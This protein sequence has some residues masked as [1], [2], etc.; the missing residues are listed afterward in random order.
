L[1]ARY[2]DPGTG[3]FLSQ[4]TQIYNTSDP[5]Q[6][7][8]YGYTANNP[9]NYIDPLGSQA[10]VEYET[11]T[12]NDEE[13]GAAA[14]EAECAEGL[15]EQQAGDDML[16]QACSANS[17]S[18]DTQVATR[19]GE[20]PIS[21]IR[22][23]D[24]VLAWDQETGEISFYPV[25]DTIHHTDRTVVRLTIDGETLTTTPE[26]PFYV[27]GQGWVKAKDLQVGAAV[28]TASG[29]SANVKSVRS[30]QTTQEM[31]NLTVDQ[32]HSFYVGEDQS[33]VHNV[34][35]CRFGPRS[36]L[37][38]KNMKIPTGSNTEAHHVIP[39]ELGDDPLVQ[40]AADAGWD[41][42]GEYNGLELPRGHGYGGHRAY[43]QAVSQ[44]LKSA[45]DPSMTP[46]QAY[47]AL[48]DIID[49]LYPIIE[50]L[51]TPLP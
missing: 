51:G 14:E 29:S 43:N 39:Y 40:R 34:A 2:Y 44:I 5:R 48:T 50:A 16:D 1:R 4:D 31:Y 28:R 42:N 45:Y 18:T 36:Q 6:L 13:S 11:L 20:K 19:D 9:V 33:L 22:I 32:A 35:S 3:R 47:H 12:E 41:M 24:Y 7:N 26:H 17:F 37:R 15:C 10:F 46:V 30:E 25:T 8:R 49:A 23:G 21:E 27:E 38:D